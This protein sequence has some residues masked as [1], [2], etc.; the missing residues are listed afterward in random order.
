[1]DG[2]TAVVSNTRLRYVQASLEKP[3][4]QLLYALASDQ[5][6]QANPFPA[7]QAVCVEAY[8]LTPLIEQGSWG[9]SE[10]PPAH[11]CCSTL[12]TPLSLAGKLSGSRTVHPLLPQVWRP[13]RHRHTT[14]Y[15]S[16]RIHSTSPRYRCEFD[17]AYK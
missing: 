9:V 7:G 3:T 4:Q 17:K 10:I 13:C 12:S 1:M 5:Q 14:T 6:L 15:A 11:C 8:Y 16:R 2:A